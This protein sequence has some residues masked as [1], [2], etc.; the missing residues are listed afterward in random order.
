MNAKQLIA[1]IAKISKQADDI[2]YD[3][4]W[5]LAQI[6]HANG[7]MTS[8][9]NL[10]DWIIEGTFDGSETLEGLVAEWNEDLE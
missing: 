9:S 5:E 3:T 1:K 4:A 8:S 6:M 10:E 2:D 7:A